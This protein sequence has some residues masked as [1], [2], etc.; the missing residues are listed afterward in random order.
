MARQILAIGNTG[1]VLVNKFNNNS[2]ELYAV[3]G[4]IG[5]IIQ[6]SDTIGDYSWWTTQ[7]AIYDTFTIT[8]DFDF[9][10]ATVNLPS[11]I[12]LLFNG[13][14]WSNGTINGDNTK[15]FVFG[16][17]QCFETDLTLTGKW[18]MPFITPQ[19]YGAITNENITPLIN[20][21]TAAIQK[22]FD[23]LFMVYLPCGYYYVA[24]ELY[25]TIPKTIIGVSGIN[26]PTVYKQ[27]HTRIYT[28][29][30]IDIITIRSRGVHIE[31]FPVIDSQNCIINTGAA[32]RLDINYELTDIKIHCNIQ[33]NQTTLLNDGNGI[34]GIH[35]DLIN[36]NHVGGYCTWSEIKGYIQGVKH[37]IYTSENIGG[38]STWI[39]YYNIDIN[40]NYS[41][42]SIRVDEQMST[43]KLKMQHQ[44][45]YCL[46]AAEKATDFDYAVYHKFY[47]TDIDLFTFDLSNGSVGSHYTN[48]YGCYDLGSNN[49]YTGL[50]KRGYSFYRSPECQTTQNLDG[51][52]NPRNILLHKKGDGILSY[53]ENELAY[54]YKRYSSYTINAYDGSGYD[55]DINLDPSIALPPEPTITIANPNSTFD[56]RAEPTTILFT[57][58]TKYNTGFVEI[59]IPWS[60]RFAHLSYF[61]NER[62]SR[63]QRIQTILYETT[64]T[65]T[66]HNVV[67]TRFD[68]GAGQSG[69]NTYDVTEI[70]VLNLPSRIIIRFIGYVLKNDAPYSYPIT[71]NDILLKTNNNYNE[72]QP[73]IDIGGG[74]TIYGNL[75]V[76]EGV[77]ESELPIYADNAA[78]KVGGLVAGDPYRTAT[79]IRMVVYD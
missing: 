54:L 65:Y 29:K 42:Q 57:D 46:T 24:S 22:C 19:Y 12:K 23:S 66:V 79:G 67:T 1:A 10:G 68:F 6:P 38:Y 2:E 53:F 16:L 28:D 59:V 52:I 15:F 47:S 7:T 35:Y 13:G 44:S 75:S 26:K 77:K 34:I 32:I 69:N 9:N 58:P 49:N 39:N 70:P 25:I 17:Q 11:N 64:G 71:I 36:L 48:G 45:S 43:G 62:W 3:S 5:Y 33:G 74:Q 27:D 50:S 18:D 76:N 51:L 14:V 31:G 8:N 20:D 55:F 73:I 37:A 63:F 21:C 40:V 72:N 78:A 56:Y 60:L 61:I 4:G 30:D 41:K